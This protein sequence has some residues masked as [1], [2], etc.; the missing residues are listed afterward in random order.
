MELE[1]ETAPNFKL[2]NSSGG[3]TE[4]DEL[5]TSGPIMLV[6]YPGDFT[7]TCTKQLCDYRDQWDQFQKLGV[8]IVG[9][10]TDP[11]DSHKKF[12]SSFKFPFPL[13]SDPSNQVAKSLKATS[14][15]TLGFLSRSV[16]IIGKN[17]EILYRYVEPLPLTRRKT[18]DLIPVIEKLKSENRL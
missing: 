1:K 2:P 13:L 18:Q 9:I 7:P 4:L 17:R 11:I 10:S 6:F 14:K 8:Q 12:I 16:V 3:T 15:W 5:L